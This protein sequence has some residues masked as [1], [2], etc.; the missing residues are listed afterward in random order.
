MKIVFMGTPEFAA[1]FLKHL[2]ESDFADVVGVVTQ[3][4]RPAGRGRVLTPPP[5]KSLALE[6]GLPVLQPV[7]LKAPEFEEELR[8]FGADLFV[9]VAY[10]ILPKNI[11]GVAKFGAVN[12]HG[13]MLPKYRGAA[14]V[15]RAIADGL[16][17]T[18]VTVFRLDEK[19]D[20]GPILAQRVIP[21]DHQDTTASL[22]EKMVAPGCE[23]LDD[24]I[25][26]LITGT[27]KDLT[28]DHAQA[29]GAPKL[30]KEEGL[31]DFSL[32]AL[33]I[34]N[35]IRAFNPWPGGYGKLGGRMVYL[36]VT[37]VVGVGECKAPAGVGTLTVGAVA[38]K[39][40]RFFVGTGEGLLEVIE[41]QAEGKKPMPVADFMR[42]IQNHEGLA[43]C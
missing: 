14:P 22:L 7:D 40:K 3:P 35:R 26:Q 39:D 5:V 2:K 24:A 25:N 33:T 21:I 41:I 42:G 30:K 18:G 8:A 16:P 13:S 23:A 27:E 34:H 31:I 17:A 10:S 28:Q 32:S 20:H 19:M 1:C 43:F 37:D 29:S 11:L 9:V 4:D 6:Y 12:V 38:F 36:R 15:Q